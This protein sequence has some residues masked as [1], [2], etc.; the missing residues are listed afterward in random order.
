M[1]QEGTI[2][3]FLGIKHMKMASVTMALACSLFALGTMPSQAAT[4]TGSDS[5]ISVQVPGQLKQDESNFNVDKSMR[6]YVRGLQLSKVEENKLS[7]YI[8]AVSL[9]ALEYEA[10]TGKKVADAM[11]A[12]V[13]RVT[14]SQL[15]SIGAKQISEGAKE[16]MTISHKP[17][18]VQT[19]SFTSDNLNMAMKVLSFVNKDDF[20]VVMPVYH[21][22]DKES[23][24]Q[25]ADV[26]KSIVMY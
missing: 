14:Y 9:D 23:E 2:M 16:Q 13:E 26:I 11:A 15:R 12:P 4:I 5:A 19:L 7:V 20:W 10:A 22:G 6:K 8:Y 18:T 3:K 17:V 25:A 21:V 1:D 24:Q